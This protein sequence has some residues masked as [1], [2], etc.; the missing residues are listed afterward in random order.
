M[1][2]ESQ[3]DGVGAKTLN[4]PDGTS[5]TAQGSAGVAS[6]VHHI[7]GLRPYP[8]LRSFRQDEATLFFGRDKQVRQLRE[9]L[10]ERN[11]LAVLGGSGSGKSSLVRAGLLPKLNSTNPIPGRSGAW[12]VVEC[13]P[14]T[15]PSKELFDAIFQ[16]IFLPV[17]DLCRQDVNAA[18]AAPDRRLRAV[19]A[20][21]A[22]EPPLKP[23]DDVERLCRERLREA[24]FSGDAIDVGGI[25]DFADSTLV[26]L[27]ERLAGGPRSGRAN[28]LILIDQ[29][30]EVF[31]LPDGSRESGLQ[32]V[33]S[34]LTNIQTFKPFNL[35]LI[36]TMRNE[37]LHRCSEFPG[38]PEALNGSTYLVD[39]LAG[40]DITR[41]IV[42]PARSALRS[43]GFKPGSDE[44]APYTPKAI[45]QLRNAFEA[46][47]VPH[48]ADQ[49]PLLQHVLPIVW[50]NA[51]KDWS[52][53]SKTKQLTIGSKH[54]KKVPGWESPTPLSACLNAHADTVLAEAIRAA[55]AATGDMVL[56]ESDAGHLIQAALCRLAIRDEKGVIRRKFATLDQMLADSGILERQPAQRE[57]LRAALAAALATFRSATLLNSASTSDGEQFDVNHEA[58]VRNWATYSS[59]V[60]DVNRTKIWL[61]EINAKIEE[62]AKL[63][64]DANVWRRAL[65]LLQDVIAAESLKAAADEVGTEAAD[66]LTRD[67]FGSN[68]P[69]SK[70]WTQSVLNDERSHEAIQ[71]QIRKAR[72]YRGNFW[73]RWRILTIVAGLTI[74]VLFL[75]ILVQL[76]LERSKQEIVR[77]EENYIKQATFMLEA[78]KTALEKH[79]DDSD[80]INSHVEALRDLTI[81][82]KKR[83]LDSRLSKYAEDSLSQLNQNLRLSLS[84]GLWLKINQEPSSKRGRKAVCGVT[85]SGNDWILPIDGVVWARD[86]NSPDRWSPKFENYTKASG[87]VNIRF[88]DHWPSGSIICSSPEGDWQFMWITG[89]IDFTTQRL[90]RFSPVIRRV[91]RTLRQRDSENKIDMLVELAEQREIRDELSRNY[92]P[93]LYADVGHIH[94]KIFNGIL[95]DDDVTFHRGEHTTSFSFRLTNG[96]IATFWTVS[97]VIDAEEQGSEGVS[98]SIQW[99]P[100]N[101]R[102][103]DRN[104]EFA[105]D[106][107]GNLGKN[108]RYKASI[109][110]VKPSIESFVE[111]DRPGAACPMTLKIELMDR[112]SEQVQKIVI[113]R[114]WSR[115]IVMG[116]GTDDGHILLKDADDKIWSYLI[117]PTRVADLSGQLLQAPKK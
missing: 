61:T 53:S 77:T 92:R 78:Q 36:L 21:L 20:A 47:D 38:V 14:R 57:Q 22:I 17:L 4:E 67:V 11:L 65:A 32:L 87:T 110:L 49:L 31:S 73:N 84:R 12:Y 52:T 79:E 106:L 24:L 7:C 42:A 82:M 59:W 27:D 34:L 94:E 10:A 103:S 2:A 64:S 13:R 90:S 16:Q 1:S 8:G 29:F 83:P 30:E 44:F 107:S 114:S 74:A 93:E 99:Q 105:C 66:M 48:A 71:S 62:S 69:F 45:A 51:A 60:D 70:R 56:S 76:S 95:L 63:S 97:G 100:C 108:Y 9:I 117:D 58:L 104:E 96:K 33:M 55:V 113:S 18:D 72:Q 102:P 111:C 54:L 80:D 6:D 23:G 115:Q 3:E 35:F 25:F 41:A 116:A 43:A 50:D 40:P 37:W 19:S 91:E 86:P 85:S 81:Q 109:E 68:A 28:L 101:K 88:A 5:E 15:D 39:L 26:R 46:T 89:A 112:K 98:H 75:G